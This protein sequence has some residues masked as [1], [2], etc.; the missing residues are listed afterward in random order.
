MVSNLMMYL[1][2]VLHCSAC[3][4]R[5]GA[6]EVVVCGVQASVRNRLA[7]AGAGGRDNSSL[8]QA[9]QFIRNTTYPRTSGSSEGNSRIFSCASLFMH[10]SQKTSRTCLVKMRRLRRQTTPCPHRPRRNLSIRHEL[11]Y[12]QHCLQSTIQGAYECFS[13]IAP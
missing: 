3:R 5:V 13:T 6:C 12:H 2:K 11:E 8:R 7:G 9:Q 10:R 1:R 4:G